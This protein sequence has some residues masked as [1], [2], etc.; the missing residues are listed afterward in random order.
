VNLD[1]KIQSSKML[2]IIYQLTVLTFLVWTVL[3]VVLLQYFWQD[4][5]QFISFRNGYE[6]SILAFRFTIVFFLFWHVRGFLLLSFTIKDNKLSYLAVGITYIR[7]QTDDEQN[8]RSSCH[9][10]YRG[11]FQ[12]SRTNNIISL[13]YRW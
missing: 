2:T 7:L 1:V 10:L 6:L 5:L 12:T 11:K 4:I 8:G 9:K 3:N 13:N